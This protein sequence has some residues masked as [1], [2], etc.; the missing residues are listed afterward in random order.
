[1]E[2]EY[3]CPVIL[4]KPKVAFRETIAGSVP[5]DYFHKKQSGGQGQYGK[6]IGIVE[7]LPPQ[8]NTKLEF[9]DETVGTNIPKNYMPGIRRGF[10]NAC[11]KGELE[12]I[13]CDIFICRIENILFFEFSGPLLGYK[14]SGIKF[15]L[16][17]G[18]SHCVDSSDYS[19]QLAAEGAMRD[20]EF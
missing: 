3:N 20:G 2:R 5:F 4:G 16:K 1:M 19:F 13:L 11:E 6:V 14:V 9:S 7:P 12:K 17:D 18:A 8:D 15:R 10:L